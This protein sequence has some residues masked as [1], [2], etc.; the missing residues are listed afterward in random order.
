APDTLRDG[1]SSDVVLDRWAQFAHR[2]DFRL[3][4]TFCLCLRHWR[5]GCRNGL[6]RDWMWRRMLLRQTDTQENS[7]DNPCC[8]SRVGAHFAEAAEADR[9]WSLPAHRN[10]FWGLPRDPL[11]GL[12]H[13]LPYMRTRLA[14]GGS[15]LQCLHSRGQRLLLVE[16][17]RARGTLHG[18]VEQLLI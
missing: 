14:T 16:P 10:G 13:P 17:D 15:R 5:R 12:Q 9:N 3:T 8:H 18:V 4:R 2:N 11:K 6:A 1:L 7:H